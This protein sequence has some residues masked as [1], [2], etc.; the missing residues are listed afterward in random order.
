MKLKIKYLPFL[1]LLFVKINFC[2]GQINLVQNPS[3]ENYT[4]CPSNSDELNKC[5]NW[6]NSS[7]TPDYFHSCSIG[8][9]VSVPYNFG[10][11]QQA[12]NGNAYAG[13]LTYVNPTLFSNN[14][15]EYISSILITP[16]NIGTKYFVSFKANLS[17]S[18]FGQSNCASNK[19]GVSF[20]K[21]SFTVSN[22]KIPNNLAKVYSANLIS[23][24]TNWTN[25]FGSFISDSAYTNIILGNFFTD[26]NTDTLTIDGSGM[27]KYSYYFLDNICVSTDSLFAQNYLNTK[28]KKNADQLYFKI[29]PNPIEKNVMIENNFSIKYNVAI[30]DLNG[31]KLR[32]L[33]NISDFKIKIELSDLTSGVFI[34]KIITKDNIDTYKLIKQ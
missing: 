26:A 27:C 29:Y 9:Y 18:N 14:T 1:I 22:P 16:L 10:G 34:L 30:E 7:L 33:N 4:A 6:F 13:I 21:T 17:I 32:D 20:S 3:F 23:D 31:N 2:K 28:I 25:I 5:N 15:R 12:A 24:T 19:I 11:Y 8:N